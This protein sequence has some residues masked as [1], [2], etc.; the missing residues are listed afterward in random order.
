LARKLRDVGVATDDGNGRLI[1]AAGNQEHHERGRYGRMTVG[2]D[3]LVR[4][5][6]STGEDGSSG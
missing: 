4:A 2:H 5:S 6:G 1:A 3:V